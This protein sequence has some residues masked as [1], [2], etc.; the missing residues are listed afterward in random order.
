MTTEWCAF[1]MASARNAGLPIPA[2]AYAGIRAWL[3]AAQDLS[4]DVRDPDYAGGRVAASGTLRSVKKGDGPLVCAAAGAAMR[5]LAGSGADDPSV[6]GPANLM[7][8]SLPA[9]NGRSADGGVDYD[10]WFHATR[11]MAARGGRHWNEWGNALGPALIAIQSRGDYA[12]SFP[13]VGR[14]TGAGRIACTAM[15][16]MCLEC[17]IQLPP[18][19]P[20]PTSFQLEQETF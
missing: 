17:I 7:L 2:E 19:P 20:S 15:A 8:R 4:G 12:G 5:M 18:G 16:A 13:A 9:W 14:S 11:L 3:N 1:A 10:L 6:T